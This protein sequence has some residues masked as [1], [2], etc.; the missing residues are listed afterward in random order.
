MTEIKDLSYDIEQLYIEGYSP[1]TIA[2]MLECPIDM[3]YDWIEQVNVEWE[4]AF[5]QEQYSPFE[6]VNS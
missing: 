2:M 5:P 6:T 4:D 3:V 1:K